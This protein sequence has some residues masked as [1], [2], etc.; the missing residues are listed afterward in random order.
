[1]QESVIVCPYCK[2][3]AFFDPS[4]SS[5]FCKSK[6]CKGVVIEQGKITYENEVNLHEADEPGKEQTRF[7]G[8][9]N[10]IED[11]KS[12]ICEMLGKNDSNQ[13]KQF[14]EQFEEG[15]KLIKQFSTIFQMNEAFTNDAISKYRTLMFD[16]V[17]EIANK[18]FLA[19]A[20]L[21]Y[22]LIISERKNQ[23][24]HDQR[25]DKITQKQCWNIVLLHPNN[26]IQF[27]RLQKQ[28]IKLTHKN[29]IFVI[30]FYKGLKNIN[31]HL[32]NMKQIQYVVFVFAKSLKYYYYFLQQ[33]FNKTI[34]IYL[35]YSSLSQSNLLNRYVASNQE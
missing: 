16:F 2:N 12:Q 22:H 21:A 23:Q 33:I 28:K 14:Y 7:G 27:L 1:M 30:K 31:Y 6:Q 18:S 20:V 25:I 35:N 9:E 19:L 29:K 32:M 26:Q 8:Y 5:N 34:Q 10:I 3:Q 24:N 17:N 4:S 11:F 15:E 13:R